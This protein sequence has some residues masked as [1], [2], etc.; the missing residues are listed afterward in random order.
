MGRLLTAGEALARNALLVPRKVGARDLSREMTYATWNRRACRLANALLG[1]GLERGDRVAILAYNCLEWLEIYPALAKAGLVALPINFRLVGRE[2]AYIL[3]DSGA[4]ALIVQAPLLAPVEEI[5]DGIDLP[6]QRLIVLGAA[7]EVPGSAD[8]EALL[9]EAS[10]AEPAL[11]VVPD[12]IAVMLYTS[13]TTGRPKGAMRSNGAEAV[14]PL[15]TGLG[16]GFTAEDTGLLVM[17]LCHANSL[18]FAMTFLALG[19]TCVVYDCPSFDPELMLGVLA[20]HS[21]SFTSLV[22]THYIMLE[23]LPERAVAR[24]DLS[25]VRRLLISSAPAR[26]DTKRAIMARFP[27]SQL[28]ELYGS[29]EGG[30]VTLLRP[31]EQMSRIGSIGREWPGIGAARLLDPEGAPVAD[32]EVGELYFST[33]AM[34]AGYW[35]LPDKTADAFRGDWCSVGDMAR[36]DKDGF[37]WLADRKANMIISGGLNVYPTEIENV[38]GEHAAVRDVAV[39]G[40]PDPKWG[41]AVHAVVVLRQGAEADGEAIIAFARERLAGYKRPRSVS[42]IGEAEMPRTATGKILHR[43]LRERFDGA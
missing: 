8:Y 42:F 11:A 34:F 33:P 13:G 30:Y 2:I 31:E 28:F 6:A 17:P 27:S 12:D 26:P 35:N 16:F 3:A 40:R 25:R 9:A 38:L 5:R 39:I 18:W 7:H 43:V 41:E 22:P 10:D 29:T 32:G 15:L 20:D 1:L 36:R 21:V 19:A 23:G 37:Y 24:H 4:R 14:M